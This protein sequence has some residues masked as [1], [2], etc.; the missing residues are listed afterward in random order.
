MLLRIHSPLKKGK[1]KF[2]IFI[3]LFLKSIID[4]NVFFLDPGF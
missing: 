4:P 2:K 3:Q 1:K